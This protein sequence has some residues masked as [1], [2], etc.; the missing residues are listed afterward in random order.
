[1]AGVEAKTNAIHSFNQISWGS[2]LIELGSDIFYMG[3]HTFIPRYIRPGPCGLDQLLLGA[4]APP[5][6]EQRLK[7]GVFLGGQ[8]QVLC[9]E[10]GRAAIEAEL[11]RSPL[12]SSRSGLA[13]R[14]SRAWMRALS[15]AG[16]NGFTR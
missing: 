4:G 15:S 11:Q 1:M 13:A 9:V 16:S 12:Q 10:A 3:F 2:S 8:P 6:F 5:G 14:R 7:Q